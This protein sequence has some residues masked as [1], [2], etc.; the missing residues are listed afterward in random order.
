M[1]GCYIHIPFCDKICIY[2]DFA[3][4]IADTPKKSAYLEAL[5]Y[6]MSLMKDTLEKTDTVYIGG[7]DPHSFKS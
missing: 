3:K 4:E 6:E 2:C 5:F 7:G 1:L